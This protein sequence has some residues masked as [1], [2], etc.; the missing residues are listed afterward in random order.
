[1]KDID[2]SLYFKKDLLAHVIVENNIVTVENFTKN[3]IFNPFL[4]DNVT[5]KTVI[6]FFNNRCFEPTRPDKKELL[7][8]L[9][10]DTYDSIEICK[11]THG[12]MAEDYCWVKFKGED[13]DY[14]KLFDW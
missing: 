6:H 11:K 5:T 10:L 14:D 4:I 2:F 13:I 9:G 12:I 7:N 8:R 1:M 3:K